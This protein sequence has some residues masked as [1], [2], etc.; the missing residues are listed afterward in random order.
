[1]AGIKD[2]SKDILIYAVGN[3]AQRAVT[4]FLLPLYTNVLSVSDYGLLETVTVTSQILLFIMDLGMSRSVLRYYSRYHDRSDLLG[5]LVS[6]ALILMTLSG[7]VFLG[8]G[9]LTRTSLSVLLLGNKQYSTI[10]VWTLIASLLQAFNQWIY[11]LFRA[12]RQSEKYVLVSVLNLIALTLL[13]IVFLRYLH[14]GVLGVLFAQVIVYLFILV[15]FF[16]SIL[17]IIDGHF[18][19]SWPLAKQL[20]NFGFPL[21]F[22]MSGMI[23]INSVDRY[24]L[25]YFRGLEEVAIYSLGIR[26]S[27]ILG[28][29]VVTP[30]QLAWGPFL[31]LEENRDTSRLVSRF[32]SYLVLSLAFV[33]TVFLLF[34]REIILLLSSQNYMDA[35]GVVPYMLLSIA[36][37]GLFYWA[38]GLVNLNEQTWKLGFIVLFAGLINIGLNLLL[39]DRWGWLGAAWADVSARGI[40]T[41]LTFYIAIKANRIAFEYRRL[42]NIFFLI[43]ISWFSYFLILD[44]LSGV[45]AI[46]LKSLVLILSLFLLFGPL[47]F[48]EAHELKKVQTLYLSL[49]AKLL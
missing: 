19:F 5:T 25:V 13:N 47:R 24:F 11:I 6:T 17:K 1:M 22:A 9:F 26:I 42:A 16:P 8:V 34:S 20:F 12:K 30:F 37:M 2:L 44:S 4:F 23:I 29:V 48:F 33:G 49:K 27:A 7:L 43:S 41:G 28:M 35:Q 18:G 39:T 31:F 21:I 40:A 14:V 46:G 45:I 15:L 32:F 3:F 10:L 38:G 36:F